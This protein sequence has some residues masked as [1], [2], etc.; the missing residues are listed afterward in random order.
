MIPYY[1]FLNKEKQGI[2]VYDMNFHNDISFFFAD[3]RAQVNRVDFERHNIQMDHRFEIAMFS[4]VKKSRR[5][6]HI[7]SYLDRITLT[8]RIM[9]D[10]T[11]IMEIIG[12][13]SLAQITEFISAANENHCNNVLAALIDY[14]NTNYGD[15][16]PMDAFVLD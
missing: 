15:F 7:V 13:F 4:I 16:D 14:K 3:C 2:S 6:N 1:K 5:S 8:D 12:D 10:D 9:D 11:S